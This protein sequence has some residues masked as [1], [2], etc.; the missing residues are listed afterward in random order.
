MSENKR[1]AMDDWYDKYDKPDPRNSD[2][3]RALAQVIKPVFDKH[4]VSTECDNCAQHLTINEISN[5]LP[6]AI[7]NNTVNKYCKQHGPRGL[8]SNNE[9][10]GTET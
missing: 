5:I 1:D 4:L 3:V 7:A 6:W 8:F 2:L 10:S 9:K